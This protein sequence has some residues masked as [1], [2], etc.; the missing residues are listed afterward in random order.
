MNNHLKEPAPFGILDWSPERVRTLGRQIIELWATHLERLPSLPVTRH[1]LPEQVKDAVTCPIPEE[2]LSDHQLLD[3]LKTLFVDHSI[4]TGHPGF[5]A[6]IMGI[7]TLPGTLADLAASAF[8]QNLGAWRLSPGATEIELYLIRFFA[9]RFGLPDTAGGITVSGGAMANFIALKVARDQ[10]GGQGLRESGLFGGQRLM[11]YASERAH[12]TI[13]RAVDMLGLGTRS[14][15]KISTDDQHRMR[16]SHLS[17]AIEQDLND[18]YVP[19]ALVGTAGTTSL[20]SIDPLDELAKLSRRYGMWFHV[21]GA[22][23]AAA[24]L[25]EGLRPLFCGI[26]KADS[27]TFDPHKWM[28]VPQ[29]ASIVLFR[30]VS[31]SANSFT[32]DGDYV[33]EDKELTGSGVD[34]SDLGP[35]WSR[36]FQAFKVWFSLLAHGRKA[37]AQRILH[38]V[39]LTQFFADCVTAHPRFELMAPPNLSICCFRYIPEVVFTE[40][41]RWESHLNK[42]NERLMTVVQNNGK[43]YP[44]NAI[45]NHKFALRICIVNFRTE[46]ETL[47]SLLDT[48]AVIGDQVHKELL[49]HDH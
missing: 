15:R 34:M 9:R 2:P 33:F 46:A 28:Y 45:V 11:L 41:E 21:D 37:I 47:T 17:E 24:L 42:L 27:I 29:S 36:G 19:F 10:K 20:G 3:H 18:G 1:L 25:A 38:D 44:S 49:S 23:G 31:Q 48:I 14:L 16:L 35:Q 26:E 6:Y 5:L 39:R 12:V 40:P 30:Q 43:F 4:H 8:N 13:D 32:S 22:Y 7:G